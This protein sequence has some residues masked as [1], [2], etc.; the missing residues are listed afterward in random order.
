MEHPMTARA[1]HETWV[2]RSI[3]RVEDPTLVTGQGRF[4]ANLPASLWV[5]FVRSPVAAGRIV[6]ITAPPGTKLVTAADLT[7]VK[8]IRPMM[9]KF[10]YVPVSQ[11]ILAT[12][13]VRFVG[14]PIAAV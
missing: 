10:N 12:D 9:H 4:T 2:G 6:R 13:V 11:P 3:R 1:K 7:G 5:R 8:P 14:E